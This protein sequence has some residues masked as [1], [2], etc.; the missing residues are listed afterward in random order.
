MSLISNITFTTAGKPRAT[1]PP[2]FPHLL[3]LKVLY[4]LLIPE[5]QGKFP[6]A[7]DVQDSLSPLQLC[8]TLS[9]LFKTTNLGSSS[10]P[11]RPYVSLCLKISV[12]F[13]Y[14]SSKGLERKAFPLN[15]CCFVGTREPCAI[16]QLLVGAN[17]FP[18]G[19]LHSS[20]N[21]LCPKQSADGKL[22]TLHLVEV[23]ASGVSCS[24]SSNRKMLE[25]Q[26]PS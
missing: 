25:T 5:A 2:P 6:M 20:A 24:V 16:S 8:L 26:L 13:T 22:H 17:A 18:S 10:F 4:V 1:F 12:L 15:F 19:R 11:V 9:L 23:K 21:L 3:L 7:G 14:E